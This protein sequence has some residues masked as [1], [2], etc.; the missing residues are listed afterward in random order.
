M[1]AILLTTG[2][3]VAC[4][5]STG[6][7]QA[8]VT[9]EEIQKSIDRGVAALLAGQNDRGLWSADGVFTFNQVAF[10]GGNES[11][12]M[13]ALAYAGVS[14]DDP[15]MQKGF[16]AL[17][18][19]KMEF[20]YTCSM[21]ILVI[22]K[23]LPKLDKRRE[24]VARQVLKQDA[25]FLVTTQQ[26]IGSW[27]YPDR[28]TGNK[29]PA[30]SDPNF[31]DFSNTQMAV[32]ALSE[33]G[34]CGLEIPAAT[35]KK[36]QDLFLLAQVDG[37]WNYGRPLVNNKPS[38]R[39]PYGSMTAAGLA[40][41]YLT[42]DYLNRGMGC[43]C[44]SGKS[45]LRDSPVDAAMAQA[46]QWLGKHFAVNTN[47]AL[48]GGKGGLPATAWAL[49]WLYACERVGLAGGTK[50]FGTHDWYAEGAEFILKSQKA[51]GTW[52]PIYDTAYA[53]CFLVKGRA[54]FLFNKL[55]FKGA[56]NNHPR[57]IANLAAWVS[58][59]KEQPIQ[60][61][62]VTLDSPP[63]EWHEAPILYISAEAALDFSADEKKKLRQFTDSGGTILF[64]ASC[65]NPAAANSW[66]VVAKEVWPEWDLKQLPRDHALFTADQKMTGGRVPVLWGIDDGLRTFCFAS[67]ADISCAWNTLAVTQQQ[68]FFVLGQNLYAYSTDHRP[69]RARLASR[70]TVT[71]NSYL[72][73]KLQAGP[74]ATLKVARVKHDG[75]WNVG[76]NYDALGHLAA[77]KPVPALT[78]AD[79]AAPTALAS[80]SVQVAHLVGRQHVALG[81]AESAALK[82]FLESGGLLL[83]EAAV[84]D[85]AFDT[86]FHKL[87][88]QI[89]L[90]L[91]PVAAG[92]PLVTGKLDPATGYDVSQVRCRYVLRMDRIGKPP[93]LYGLF[94][95]DRQVGL[96]SPLDLSFSLTGCDAWACRGYEA[97]DALAVATNILLWASTR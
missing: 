88:E 43:P 46:E 52:G 78:V 96:Y 89:G 32:L 14:M 5:L 53:I 82:K 6:P 34:E 16:D 54:P 17:M 50:Y 21:R 11:S 68:P 95:G 36:A 19:I 57:D 87:A 37:G 35:M 18:Q 77:G 74:K 4:L 90:T 83:A 3:C 29:N 59:A 56:W 71:K 12:A 91:K 40:S 85:E 47:P 73:T 67:F 28:N 15:K 23:L 13:L 51:D 49:Y 9:D 64:E 27:E 94:L 1:A 92:D 22:A 80:A 84:G 79:P 24:A 58:K 76:L 42:R 70:K 97:E 81:E 86:E 72:A 41:L 93:L 66:K 62:V 30:A 48:I 60:W 26:A 2:F 45:A 7:L 75:D 44:R 65:A 63:D 20:T 31:F 55:Q 33:A 10:P 69:L 25:A 38:D 61:Q 39:P 8:A